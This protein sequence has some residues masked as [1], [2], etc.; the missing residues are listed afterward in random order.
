MI[1]RKLIVI[2]AFGAMSL[3]GSHAEAQQA[4]TAARP[5]ITQSLNERQ[6]VPLAGNV[7]PDVRA[8][9]AKSPAVADNTRMDHIQM[10]LRRSPERDKAA[11]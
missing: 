4:A 1:S 3:A 2:S 5:L 8:A 6:M 7:R 11:A 10:L 9:A